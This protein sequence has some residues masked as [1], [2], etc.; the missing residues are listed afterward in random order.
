MKWRLPILGLMVLSLVSIDLTAQRNLTAE[1]ILDRMTQESASKQAVQKIRSIRTRGTVAYPAMNMQ[2]TI[3]VNFKKPNRFLVKMNVQG[4]G[5]IM[6]GYDGKVGWERSP[7]TGLRE[8][9]GAELEQIRLNSDPLGSYEWRKLLKNPRLA[10]TAKVGNRNAHVIEATS[11]GGASMKYYIDTQNF[12]LLRIDMPVITQQG[13]LPATT[14]FEDYRRVD[15]ILYPFTTRQTAAGVEA[16]IRLTEV[17]HNVS[18][19]D[20]IFRKPKQ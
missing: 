2:G 17:K 15:G 14:Y 8:I 5:E 13:S 6:Q 7:L 11:I 16:V 19:S 1:Q 18:M 3:E 9:K 10:G 12:R 4:L 20:S